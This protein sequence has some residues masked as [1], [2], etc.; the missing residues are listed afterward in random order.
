MKRHLRACLPLAAALL[1][2]IPTAGL[3]A[4]PATALKGK[5]EPAGSLVAEGAKAIPFDLQDIDGKSVTLDGFSGKKAVLM[6]FWSFFCGPCREEI[7]L[8]DEISKKYKNDLEMLAINLDGPKMDKAVRK[9]M[10]SNG[11]AFRVLWEKI[12]GVRYVT[13]DAYGVAG[14]PT[15][16]AVSKSG[17]VTWAHVGRAESSKIEAEVKKAIA[18]E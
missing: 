5:T 2:T 3:S 15:V 11:F 13:A 6:A 9:Y 10:T 8:L 1:L 18:A 14:T 7:P 17:K 4:D 12:E 16:V